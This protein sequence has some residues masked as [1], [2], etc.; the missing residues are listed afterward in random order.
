MHCSQSIAVLCAFAVAACAG[1]SVID[2]AKDWLLTVPS[3]TGLSA[4][5]IIQRFAAQVQ[6]KIDA[7]RES[8]S[9]YPPFYWYTLMTYFARKHARSWHHSKRPTIPCILRLWGRSE[10]RRAAEGSERSTDWCSPR[11]PSN[12]WLG[13]DKGAGWVHQ[14]RKGVCECECKPPV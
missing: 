4:P 12:E 2:V 13:C 11:F 10:C 14:W 9:L 8:S 6:P 7:I 3:D 5:E 1:M